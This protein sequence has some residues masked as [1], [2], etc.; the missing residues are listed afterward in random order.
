LP[1]DFPT[2]AFAGKGLMNS[3]TF[4]APVGLPVLKLSAVLPTAY[5][6]L[7]AVVEKFHAEGSYAEA[8]GL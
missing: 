4:F 2:A 1:E 5:E 6:R 3:R 7:K 8:T